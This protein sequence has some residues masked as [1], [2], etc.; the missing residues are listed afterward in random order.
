MVGSPKNKLAPWLNLLEA[1]QRS[2]PIVDP[3][4]KSNEARVRNIEATDRLIG[5]WTSQR[6]RAE[7]SKIFGHTRFRMLKSAISLRSRTILTCMRE[8]CLS[9]IVHPQ[10]GRIVVPDSPIR[11]HEVDALEKVPSPKLV[12][13]AVRCCEICNSAIATSMSSWPPV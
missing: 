10:F 6:T 11:I 12:S 5:D 2:D 8:G 9:W 4:F 1:I 3:Q 7:A 13:T